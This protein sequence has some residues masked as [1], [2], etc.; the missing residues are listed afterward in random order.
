M[1]YLDICCG[2]SQFPTLP[3]PHQQIQLEV[4][5]GLP[6]VLH[7]TVLGELITLIQLMFKVS[8][9]RSEVMTNGQWIN[10][11]WW[12]PWLSCQRVGYRFGGCWLWSS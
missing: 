3:Y 4:V 9:L 8:C 11:C 2:E 10:G 1:V 7:Q 12:Q 5:N 6:V